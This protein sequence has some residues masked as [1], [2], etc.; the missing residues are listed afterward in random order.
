MTAVTLAIAPPRGRVPRGTCLA[1]LGS[2]DVRDEIDVSGASHSAVEY[3]AVDEASAASMPASDPPARGVVRIGEP[4]RPAD[5]VPVSGT[6][7]A[8]LIGGVATTQQ[9]KPR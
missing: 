5:P 3:D 6:A 1:P 7:I 9:E 8:P 2:M 4:R